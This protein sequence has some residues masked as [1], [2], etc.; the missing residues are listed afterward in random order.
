M[1][2]AM[3]TAPRSGRATQWRSPVDRRPTGIESSGSDQAAKRSR[4]GARA[5]CAESTACCVNDA[6]GA[7]TGTS[8]AA[9]GSADTLATD[10]GAA[11]PA[12]ANMQGASWCGCWPVPGASRS[13]GTCAAIGTGPAPWHILMRCPPSAGPPGMNP[14][15]MSRRNARPGSRQRATSRRTCRLRNLPAMD[16]VMRLGPSVSL[17]WLPL[18]PASRSPPP[19]SHQTR[20]APRSRWLAAADPTLGP[21]DSPWRGPGAAIGIS[22]DKAPL[23]R[24][25]CLCGQLS[26]GHCGRKLR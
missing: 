4:G 18:L 5:R 26:S 3:R 21:G 8:V 20:D 19:W 1:R 9:G 16:V 13:G 12:A 25:G 10:G 14:G 15:G 6:Q 17:R 24:S 7:G 11:D 23:A 22:P 2:I